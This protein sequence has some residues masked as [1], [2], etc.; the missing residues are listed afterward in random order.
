[1]RAVR[2][3]IPWGEHGHAVDIGHLLGYDWTPGIGQEDLS[4]RW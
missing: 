3:G 2:F 1:M 4:A